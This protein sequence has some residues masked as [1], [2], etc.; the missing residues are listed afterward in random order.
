M[1]TKLKVSSFILFHF[2]SSVIIVS[3]NFGSSSV[4]FFIRIIANPFNLEY[5]IVIFIHYEPR[6]AVTIILDL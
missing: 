5:T 6:I 2:F 1:A 3:V 4:Q